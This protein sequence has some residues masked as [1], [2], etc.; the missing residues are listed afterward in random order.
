MQEIYTRVYVADVQSCTCIGSDWAIIHA[1]KD[2][3]HKRAIGYSGSLDKKHPNYLV[4]EKENNLYLNMIDP[5]IPLFQEDLFIAFMAFAKKHWEDGKKLLIHCNQG[6]SRA[7]SLALLF[8]AKGLSEIDQSSYPNARIQF[9]K[10]YSRYA[11]GR[12]IEKYF[13]DNW[14]KLGN[15]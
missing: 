1:C 6:Q 4:F 5:P 13:T 8:L 11:P 3:C 14:D 15:G 10:L 12:G 7:P 9:E 2:P